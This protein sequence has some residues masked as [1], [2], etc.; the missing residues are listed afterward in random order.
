MVSERHPFLFEGKYQWPSFISYRAKYLPFARYHLQK[1]F[2]Q[3][4]T[5][6]MWPIQL[7]M[8]FSLIS[9]DLL[10]D[11]TWPNFSNLSR[12]NHDITHYQRTNFR[13]F[14]IESICRWQNKC[15]QKIEISFGKGRKHCEK[16]GKCWLP[17]FSPFLT[18]FSKASFTWA[19]KTRDCL[20]K[21]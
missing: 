15:I 17:A 11:I 14:Q 2:W 19:L 3:I 21:I 16:R 7:C 13:L 4:F 1:T 6:I 18:M 10:C 8:R 9:R 12:Y 20:G 5:L